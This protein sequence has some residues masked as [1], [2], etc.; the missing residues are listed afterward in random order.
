MLSKDKNRHTP[1]FVVN[2]R[3]FGAENR[4]GDILLYHST[5]EIILTMPKTSYREETEKKLFHLIVPLICISFF[6][7][8]A[9]AG[10]SYTSWKVRDSRIAASLWLRN[11][12]QSMV[13]DILFKGFTG[14]Q[15]TV[16]TW[17]GKQKSL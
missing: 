3:G 12:M 6:S 10:R 13:I 5:Q 7:F 11:A 9:D 15:R 16:V 4:K 17:N 2:S 8:V 14:V 1:S